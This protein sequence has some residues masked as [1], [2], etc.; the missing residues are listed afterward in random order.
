MTKFKSISKTCLTVFF[1]IMISLTIGFSL[2]FRNTSADE[3]TGNVVTLNDLRTQGINFTAEKTKIREATTTYDSSDEKIVYGYSE[4]KNGAGHFTYPEM[5]NFYDL[6]TLKEDTYKN[7]VFTDAEMFSTT[8]SSVPGATYDSGSFL[9]TDYRY[10]ELFYKDANGDYQDVFYDA[11]VLPD[12]TNYVQPSNSYYIIQN[13][14]TKNNLSKGISTT[15]RVDNLYLSFGDYYTDTHQLENTIV[16][17]QVTAQLSNKSYTNLNIGTSYTEKA[18]DDNNE[19]GQTYFGTVIPQTGLNISGDKRFNYFWYIYLDLEN[20]YAVDNS[21]NYGHLY[22]NKIVDTEGRYDITISFITYNLSGQGSNQG[23]TSSEQK[24][25]YSFY[26]INED[27]YA[28]YP[29][30]NSVVTAGDAENKTVEYRNYYYNFLNREYP[31]FVYNPE[32]FNVSYTHNYNDSIQEY[33]T[34]FENTTAYTYNNNADTNLKFETSILS[35]YKN[36]YS[37]TGVGNQSTIT[38]IFD[39]SIAVVSIYDKSIENKTT[40][41]HFYYKSNNKANATT[42]ITLNTENTQNGFIKLNGTSM[43][44]YWYSEKIEFDSKTIDIV[45]VDIVN[46]LKKSNVVLNSIKTYH[47][48]I[49][50]LDYDNLLSMND[51]ENKPENDINLYYDIESKIYQPAFEIYNKELTIDAN[52]YNITGGTV[53]RTY[54]NYY[55]KVDKNSDKDLLLEKH[56]E[57]SNV[58]FDNFITENLQTTFTPLLDFPQINNSGDFD[59]KISET[60][61]NLNSVVSGI[62]SPSF[63]RVG[64]HFHKIFIPLKRNALERAI[65]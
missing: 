10:D 49:D 19:L 30:F 53:D 39:N 16:S 63:I 6:Y 11:E 35:V 31:S 38:K 34:Q 20:I 65:R 62:L 8:A 17:L 64:E 61:A 41:Y 22:G 40:A 33:S 26:L 37:D 23:T 50:T 52:T 5:R 13:Y 28:N 12:G 42:K 47:S 15:E 29:E 27:T 44:D 46:G 58:N 54:L 45:N 4:D 51:T 56:N 36:Q 43:F 57:F 48:T 14:E 21:D 55:F 18:P 1:C 24:F 59:N 9:P 7:K 32:K 60:N 25:K 2:L 3:P